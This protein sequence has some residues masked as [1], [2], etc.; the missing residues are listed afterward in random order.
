MIEADIVEAVIGLGPNLFYNSPMEACVLV[1]NKGKKKERLGKVLF[2]NAVNEVKRESAFSC[3]T[4]EHI[5]KIYNAFVDYKDIEGFSKA[6][7][8][9]TILAN[10]GNLNIALYVSNVQQK[11]GNRDV[12]LKDLLRDWQKESV[13][14]RNECRTF[15]EIL[16]NLVRNHHKK[17]T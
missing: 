9:K 2:I 5:K 1:C 16:Y 4:E 6:L 15:C 14:L 7:P 11:N 17:D 8:L 10:N 3:L 12:Q 13:Q